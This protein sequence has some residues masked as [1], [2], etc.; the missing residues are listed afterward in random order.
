MT[1]DELGAAIDGFRE[2][3]GA[4]AELAKQAAELETT[5]ASL[6]GARASV[7]RLASE[8][9]SAM[10]GISSTAGR[11]EELSGQL[12]A[13]TE[14]LRETDPAAVLREVAR[15]EEATERLGSRM[16]EMA[17][18]LKSRVEQH[19]QKVTA[20]LGTI[21]AAI[22]VG[23]KGIGDSIGELRETSERGYQRMHGLA[24]AIAAAAVLAVA[25]VGI[26]V[27]T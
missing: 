4:L 8:L 5:T 15:I 26:L 23:V 24:V 7:A 22:D 12:A 21:R 13:A 20:E 6:D 19:D 2:A 1:T 11:L 14:A 9:E 10:R 25:I 18:D 27:A 16:D 17:G 3:E